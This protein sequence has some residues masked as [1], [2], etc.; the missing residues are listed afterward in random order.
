MQETLL[1]AWRGFG[2]YQPDTNI[3]AWLFRI[4]FNTFYGQGRRRAATL[5]PLSPVLA[6]RSPGP[7]DA[8]EVT[9]A[10]DALEPDH[11]AVLM[12]GV[13]EGFSCREM[14]EILDVP[15]GTVMS[16]MSRAREAMRKLIN[17]REPHRQPALAGTHGG[18]TR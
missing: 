11:R 12:L 6:L 9:R 14:A 5:V 1:L 2:R 7:D 17:H 8:I 13:V 10:L 16:R 15:I 4:L 18:A 3:R